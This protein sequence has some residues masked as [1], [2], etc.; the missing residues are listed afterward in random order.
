MGF[1]NLDEEERDCISF[2]EFG[3]PFQDLIM[4][5]HIEKINKIL[6]ERNKHADSIRQV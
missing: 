2:E 4:P 5:D 6:E 1:H 3:I